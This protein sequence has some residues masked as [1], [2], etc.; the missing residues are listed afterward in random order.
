MTDKKY[1]VA[2]TGMGKRGKHHADFFLKNGRFELVGICD[3]VAETLDE[4]AGMFGDPKKFTDTKKMLTETKPDIFCFCTM[5]TIRKELIAC[6]IDAG[7]KLIA[8]EKPIAMSTTE[9]LE[10]MEMIK[11]SG[12]K[13]G[14]LNSTC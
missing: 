6:G 11:K 1:T 7:V 14:L 8:F 12:V 10:I 2:I 4:A 13:T 3:V 9:A 5:P